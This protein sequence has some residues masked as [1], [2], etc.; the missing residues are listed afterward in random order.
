[1]S[2]LLD[3]DT[4]VLDALDF[5]PTCEAKVIDGRCTEEVTHRLVCVECAHDIGLT[6]IDHAIYARRQPREVT[7][8]ACGTKAPM[9]DL[10]I[11]EAI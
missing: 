1:M 9:R 7:H 11:V 5:T 6:C 10:V 3:L 8:T 2:T 4:V